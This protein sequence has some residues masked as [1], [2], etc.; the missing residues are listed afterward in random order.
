M[1]AFI[2]A[3]ALKRTR[4]R[5]FRESNGCTGTCV[6]DIGANVRSGPSTNYGIVTTVG[7]GAKVSVTG[8]SGN[9]WSVIANGKNGYILGSLL[10]VPGTV[11]SGIGLNIRSGPSTSYQ[12]VG[13]LANGASITIL[14]IESGWYKISRGYV[15]AD[16]VTLGGS[17][18]PAPQ[19]GTPFRM[20][21]VSVWQGD[22]DFHKVKASGIS[23]VMIRSS[24][25][26]YNPSQVDKKFIR[27]I[28]GAIAAGMTIGIY[29]YGYAKSVAQAEA[30]ADFCLRTIAPYK[31]HIKFP[32][33]YD[34][35]DSSMNVGATT[36]ANMIVAF[37]N[38]VRAAGYIPWLYANLN[39]ARNY[40]NMNIVHNNG[41]DFWIAQYSSSCS[42]TGK[43]AAW[44]YSRDRKS[45]V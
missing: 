39:W 17:P 7:Y 12:I 36:V 23:H 8:S 10:N 5:N 9:W 40:I 34:V 43:Y 1:F 32:V 27:N 28:E 41:I 18:S 38:K 2:F 35:E 19:P 6:A 42:Y 22:I 37:A 13:S 33:A 30:E 31:A 15:C 20:L 24:Y 29:H 14:A 25:G 3:I 45:V 16:Y 44:Q 21:D 4:R 11:N 26:S